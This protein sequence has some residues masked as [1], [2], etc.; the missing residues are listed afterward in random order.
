M[1]FPVA[2]A[3]ATVVA[4][5]ALRAVLFVANFFHPVNGQACEALLNGDV[6][7]GRGGRGAVP[8]FLPRLK[9]DH[10]PRMN[11]LNRTTPALG[12]ATASR[13]DQGLAQRVAVPGG[14]SARLERDTGT[15]RACRI[16]SPEEGV[17]AYRAGKMLG[18]SFAV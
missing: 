12:P 4:E 11:V 13:H 16:V 14:P 3:C 1:V 2:L 9:P 18:W 8:V 5:A 17:N 15:S 6:R 10:V 7:H